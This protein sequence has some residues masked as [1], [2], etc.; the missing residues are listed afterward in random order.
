M[1]GRSGRGC[2]PS[3]GKPGYWNSRR[4]ESG[5]GEIV[6]KKTQASVRTNDGL[7]PTSDGL[8][9]TSVLIIEKKHDLLLRGNKGTSPCVITVSCFFVDIPRG[10]HDTHSNCPPLLLCPAWPTSLAKHPRPSSLSRLPTLAV[11]PQ[12]TKPGTKRRRRRRHRI[13]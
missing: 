13:T 5:C 9:P 7:H 6:G 3:E 10:L 12:D 2:E 8:H 4:G 11:G 1:P